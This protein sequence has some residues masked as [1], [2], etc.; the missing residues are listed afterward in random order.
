[1]TARG[2][3][4]VEKPC[5][6]Q[7]LEMVIDNPGLKPEKLADKIISTLKWPGKEPELEGM[8]KK[9]RAKRKKIKDIP[10]DKPWSTATLDEYPIAP[11]ALSSVLKVWKLRIERGDEFDTIT[12]REAKWAA[13]LSGLTADTG[14]LLAW[15]RQYARTELFYEILGKKDF[16]SES[17]DRGIM[18]APQV[19]KEGMIAISQG[20]MQRLRSSED[21]ELQKGKAGEIIMRYRE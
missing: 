6:G 11:E 16:N 17:L 19:Y 12:I 18:G 5:E 3:R 2:K 14:Q 7:I 10:Q 13:R 1:M 15:A 8:T 9:V 21:V 4:A 20:T